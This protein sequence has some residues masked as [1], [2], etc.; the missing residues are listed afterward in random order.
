M[1]CVTAPSS[2]KL[3]SKTC[4]IGEQR[5]RATGTQKKVRGKTSV[6]NPRKIVLEST[7]NVFNQTC[8]EV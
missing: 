1:H 2:L 4:G 5:S 6:I 7:L 8:Y 3:I